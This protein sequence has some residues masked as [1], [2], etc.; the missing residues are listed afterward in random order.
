[1]RGKQLVQM[2]AERTLKDCADQLAG[3]F[4]SIFNLLLLQSTVLTCFKLAIIIP[5]QKK[6]TLNCIYDYCTLTPIITKCFERPILPHLKSAVPA[7]LD[8]HQFAYR[9]NRSTKDAIIT[10]LDLENT[11]VRMLLVD[12]SST[13]NIVVPHKQVHKLRNLG[14]V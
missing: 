11:Y 7:N 3:V 10:A 1:M 5:I 2:D 13:L 9:A 4:T 6:S 14:A 12:F 8:R